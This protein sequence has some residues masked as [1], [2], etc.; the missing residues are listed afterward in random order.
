VTT[1]ELP[2]EASPGGPA[3]GDGA[4]LALDGVARRFGARAAVDGVTLDVRPA[5]L[6]A[7][8]GPSGSG[9]T[10]LLRLIAGFEVPDAGSVALGG[11]VVADDRTWVEPEH[12]G[13]GLVPQGDALFPHL[14][15]GENVAFGV[16]RDRDR[17]ARAL[18]L[19]G[20]AHRADS[21]PGELSGGE[22]QRVAL[23]RALAPGPSLVL[24]DEPFSSLD[25]ALRG[26]LRRD[27][28]DV[29][30][31]SGATGVLVT[32]DQ[33]EALG[34]CDRVALMRDGRV[35]QCASPT[36]LYWRP[37]DAWV[38]RFLGEVN[39]LAADLGPD[40][41]QTPL[42]RFP[43]PGA[44]GRRGSAEVGVR[45]E[46]LLLEAHESGDATVV[47]REFRGH[48]VLYQLRHAI[49]GTILVQL[50]SLEL[51]DVGDR[52][53]VRPHELAAAAVLDN[54]QT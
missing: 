25:A 20:L 43:A 6:F 48:D 23:A 33:E 28:I 14:T 2:I 3:A 52:V 1:A 26:R 24:L 35:V 15:V 16:R 12:R 8:L 21:H 40:G 27:V 44:T 7:V 50:P 37:A 30:R 51:F 47:T 38:A 53:R 4:A 41:A 13:V 46:Q 18:D 36:E 32:H 31:H 39:V 29:L 19:V 34:L 45:P 54:S 42:G 5:E 9:K 49:A 17:A 22:R 10:T 11:D